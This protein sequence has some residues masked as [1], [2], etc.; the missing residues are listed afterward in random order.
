MDLI[1]MIPAYNGDRWIIHFQCDSTLMNH[2]YT[3]QRKAFSLQAVQE[4]TAYIQRRYERVIR[5]L[6]I[7]GRETTSMIGQQEKESRSRI[8]HLIHLSRM[9]PPSD[10][11]VIITK[12]RSI[13]IGARL[14]EELWPEIAKAAGYLTNRS[15]SR[16]V[17]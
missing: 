2:V 4:F 14:P 17:D 7:D 3:M 16:Q 8:L 9:S 15:P 10:L 1:Q 5:F 6:R 11:G 12:A 13:R